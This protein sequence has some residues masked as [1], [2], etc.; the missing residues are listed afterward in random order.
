MSLTNFVRKVYPYLVENKGF[1]SIYTEN[2]QI[3]VVGNYF[4]ALGIVFP[5]EYSKTN[6]LF[7]RTLGFGALMNA[8]PKFFGLCLVHYKGFRVQDAT[9]VFR[10]ISHFDFSEWERYGSGSAAE[11]QAG[12]DVVSELEDAFETLDD[13]DFKT[14]IS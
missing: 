4:R 14:L 10:E 3:D 11:K 12:D 9:K 13:S 6:S 8:L 1:L 2:E 7:F 5:K